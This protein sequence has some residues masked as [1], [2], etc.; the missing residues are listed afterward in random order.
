MH[1]RLFSERERKLLRQFLEA[2][3]VKDET[4]RM[5][6]MRIKRNYPLISEDYELI[7]RIKEKL[8]E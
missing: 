4:F 8:K 6:R 3:E 2:G 7:K 1:T 5:L